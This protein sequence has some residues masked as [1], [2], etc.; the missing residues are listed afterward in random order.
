M[1]RAVKVTCSKYPLLLLLKDS[2]ALL[3]VCGGAGGYGG[4][5][6]GCREGVQHTHVTVKVSAVQTSN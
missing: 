5:G 2:T 6:W 3:G 4:W 1:L